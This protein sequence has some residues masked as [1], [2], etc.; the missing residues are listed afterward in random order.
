M[1]RHLLIVSMSQISKR[2]E[3]VLNIHT[4]IKN[5]KTFYTDSNGLEEQKKVV[6][7]VPTWNLT[8]QQLVAGN[9]YPI[10]SHI[11]IKNA[12]GTVSV[13]VERPEE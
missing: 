1:S 5:N 7:Y 4:D 11:K 2:K 8:V 9:Y 12:F 3:I 10:N 13:L 6:D